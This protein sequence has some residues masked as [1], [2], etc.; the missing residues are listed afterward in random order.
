M[1]KK[2]LATLS[3]VIAMLSSFITASTLQ[4]L[5]MTYPVGTRTF[6]SVN[7]SSLS[8]DKNEVISAIE[9]LTYDKGSFGVLS[10][11]ES[12]SHD[13]VK[14]FYFGDHNSAS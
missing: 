13:K 4:S 12:I 11:V 8:A 5:E 10:K 1:G 3:L 2:I 9:D 14:L 7:F 6:I